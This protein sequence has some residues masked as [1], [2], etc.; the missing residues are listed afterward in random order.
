VERVPRHDNG[1]RGGAMYTFP[2]ESPI[3]LDEL[4]ARLAR[5][6]DQALVR[7]GRE[8]AYMSSPKATLGKPPREAFVI[9]LREAREEWR[10][11]VR[12]R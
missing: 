4:P 9:Q 1:G 5:M 7:F 10:R 12:A 11:R 2:T 3:G 8:A 6:S